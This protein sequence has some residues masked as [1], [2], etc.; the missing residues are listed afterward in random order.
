MISK[1]Y[2]QEKMREKPNYDCFD[3]IKPKKKKL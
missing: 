3:F 1:N 2:S